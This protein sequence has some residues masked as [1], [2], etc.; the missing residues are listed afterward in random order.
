[1]PDAVKLFTPGN[2]EAETNKQAV[3]DAVVGSLKG[4][5]K[6]QATD[7]VAGVLGDPLIDPAEKAKRIL[8][9]LRAYDNRFAPGGLLESAGITLGG[10]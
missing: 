4:A 6:K 3:I 10:E 9:L 2:P 8:G 7:R 5:D 1:L